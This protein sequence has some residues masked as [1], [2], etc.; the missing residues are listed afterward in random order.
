[1]VQNKVNV[2]AWIACEENI[3]PGPGERTCSIRLVRD[4]EINILTARIQIIAGRGCAANGARIVHVKSF[5]PMAVLV[6]LVNELLIRK[7]RPVDAEDVAGLRIPV[8]RKRAIVD[9]PVRGFGRINR[10]LRATG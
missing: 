3:V 9:L 4:P 2:N 6:D 8:D 10:D 1:V 5:G 7:C